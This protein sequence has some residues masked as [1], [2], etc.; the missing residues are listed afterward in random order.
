M[1]EEE[2]KDWLEIT[3]TLSTPF[4]GGNEDSWN[5]IQNKIQST[6][7][8]SLQDY[9]KKPKRTWRYLTAA[10]AILLFGFALFFMNSKGE[11]FIAQESTSIVLPDQNNVF[12]FKGSEIKFEKRDE[13]SF[14]QLSGGAIF[15]VAKGSDFVVETSKGKIS[16]LG[17]VFSVEEGLEHIFVN[18]TEGKVKFED[19]ERSEEIEKG[20][21]LSIGPKHMTKRSLN[22]ME[23]ESRK[24]GELFFSEMPLEE[25]IFQLERAYDIKVQSSINLAGKKYSGNFSTSNLKQALELVCFPMNLDYKINGSVVKLYE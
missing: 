17:T 25:V 10:A 6:P 4:T 22:L 19:A 3:K 12:L 7:V 2:N 20:E 18:C 23:L 5:A 14:I 24:K 8:Y 15:E 11:K 21:G 13:Q 9:P 1:L 16:V